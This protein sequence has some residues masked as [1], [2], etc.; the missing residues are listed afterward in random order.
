MP[1]TFVP[2]PLDK[3]ILNS[4]LDDSRVAFS[5]LGRK[6]RV[7]AGTIHLRV[8]KMRE[9]GVLKGSKARVDYP[10]LGIDV[11]AYV[12]VSLTGASQL[13][14]VLDKLNSIPEIVEA[15][16]TTGSYSLLIKVAVPS[17]RDL[18][19]LLMEQVQAIESIRSTETFIILNS[20]IERDLQF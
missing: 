12:G 14:L 4:L 1:D 15:H 8:N 3:K 11:F 17:M 9:A 2:D 6:F 16:Y 18:H 19:V 7:A 10:K 20:P 13:N 5:E